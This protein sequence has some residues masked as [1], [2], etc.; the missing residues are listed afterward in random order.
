MVA[1]VI[2]LLSFA[3][4]LHAADAPVL[5]ILEHVEAKEKIE[6]KI[7]TKGGVVISPVKDKPQAKWSIRAGEALTAESRPGERAVNFF[8]GSG[9]Q[10]SLLFIV[11]VRYFQNSAGQWVPQFQLNEEPLVVR[12]KD[13]RW[14][15]L[16]TIQGVPSLIV[17][18]GSTLPNAEGY[19]AALEL[20]FTT[21]TASID[22]W[23]VR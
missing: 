15:P 17:Q 13:G 18:T 22:A 7:E 1:F 14:K 3:L 12:G 10:S 19:S 2:I 4:G 23:Q 8:Q 21:G 5:M 9:I 16:T 11:R 20:G 6:T